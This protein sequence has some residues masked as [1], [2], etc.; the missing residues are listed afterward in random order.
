MRMSFM[1]VLG[2]FVLAACSPPSTP[3]SEI[4]YVEPYDFGTQTA[5]EV[6]EGLEADYIP[7]EFRALSL[8]TASA[9]ERSL[10]AILSYRDFQRGDVP[11]G[12][13]GANVSEL[14]AFMNT[15]GRQLS[16]YRNLCAPVGFFANSVSMMAATSKVTTEHADGTVSHTIRYGTRLK[17]GKGCK[18]ALILKE[19][20][21]PAMP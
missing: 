4:G 6:A 10:Y 3:P 7:E 1:A 21:A 20:P 19:E 5:Y 2:C 14:L 12:Y 11:P 17:P 15:Y 9:A 13:R 16:D 8:P 18:W